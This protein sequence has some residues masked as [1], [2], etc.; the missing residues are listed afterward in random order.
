V[1]GAALAG[2]ADGPSLAVPVDGATD[3]VVPEQAAKTIAAA[4]VKTASRVD[5]FGDRDMP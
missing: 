4:A 3:A 1:N 2:A 5:H